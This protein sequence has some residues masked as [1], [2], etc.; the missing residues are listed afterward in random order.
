MRVC[1]K[2]LYANWFQVTKGCFKTS[3]SSVP[4]AAPDLNFD[5]AWNE[6]IRVFN[7]QN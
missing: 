7:V 5:L 2:I 3:D 4:C 6:E 1:L